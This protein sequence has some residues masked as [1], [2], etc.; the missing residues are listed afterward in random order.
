M[1]TAKQR[2]LFLDL[3][4]TVI[5]EW[6]DFYVPEY[7]SMKLRKFIKG[8]N[9][10]RIEIFSW[11][12]WGE[13][14]LATFDIYRDSIALE[15]GS[16]FDHVHDIQSLITKYRETTRI[17]VMDQNDFFDFIKKERFLFDM[18]MAGAYPNKHIVLLDDAVT[19]MKIEIGTTLIEVVNF[20]NDLI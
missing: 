10:H 14:E 19:S 2:I 16:P 18:A 5:P 13:S 17:R 3:E 7:Y 15:V 20:Q 12:I 4:E 8:F 1:D 11:A 9:P 6:G